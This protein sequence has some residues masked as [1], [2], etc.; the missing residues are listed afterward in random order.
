LYWYKGSL[1]GVEYG[2]GAYRVV[3]WKLSADG[4]EARSSET[5]ERGTEMVRNPTAGAIM[6]GKF[7]F[8]ANTGIANLENGKIDPKKLQPLHSRRCD[9]E[10]ISN[11]NV[12]FPNGRQR[13]PIP[14]RFTSEL[15]V[16]RPESETSQSGS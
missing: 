14:N 12:Q 11:R 13:L 4:G 1:V 9:A 8:M 2:T 5:L 10:V 7:Y 15:P 16:I 6:D 3:R